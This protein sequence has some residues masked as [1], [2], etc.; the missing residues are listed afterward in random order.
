M[1]GMTDESRPTV[2]TG[3]DPPGPVCDHA[4]EIAEFGAPRTHSR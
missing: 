4:Y 3:A 2:P 1:G